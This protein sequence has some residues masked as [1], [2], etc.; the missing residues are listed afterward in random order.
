M[1]VYGRNISRVDCAK[2]CVNFRKTE[3]LREKMGLAQKLGERDVYGTFFT[4]LVEYI[5]RRD[6]KGHLKPRVMA[7]K[8]GKEGVRN[9]FLRN[10]YGPFWRP[11]EVS[12]GNLERALGAVSLGIRILPGNCLAPLPSGNIGAPKVCDN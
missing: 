11:R 6:F 9:S 8:G 1:R 3:P 12:P 4:Q 7:F 2:Y 10:F 5:L